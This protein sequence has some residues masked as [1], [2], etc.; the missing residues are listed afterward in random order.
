LPH[1]TSTSRVPANYLSFLS[2]AL[3]TTF[4]DVNT[5]MPAL[6]LQAGGSQAQVGV[7]TGIMF[8]VAL[9]AQFLLAGFILQMAEEP[10]LLLGI[11]M[12]VAALAGVPWTLASAGSLSTAGVVPVVYLWMLL[13]AASGAFAGVSYKDIVGKSFEGNGRRQFFVARQVVSAAGRQN[14]AL[15]ARSAIARF[16]YPL[17]YQLLFP[18]WG[19]GR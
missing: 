16:A 13:F 7:L 19:G 1:R 9:V 14:S 17:L 10:F 5:V 18:L 3:A 15:L 4:T 12:R 11:N 6:I 8:G 2:L